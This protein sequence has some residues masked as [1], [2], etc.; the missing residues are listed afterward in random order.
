MPA[1]PGF[2]ERLSTTIV[3][4]LVDVEDRHPVDR[5]ARVVAR[6][7]IGDVV[8]ADD[9][10]DVGARE[11]RVD[12]VHVEERRIRDVGFGEQHVHVARHAAGDGVDRVLDLD[13]LLLELVGEFADAVLRLRDGHAVAGHDDHLVRVREHRRDVVDARGADGPACRRRGT[14]PAPAAT[15]AERAEEHVGDRAVHRF[16][17]HAA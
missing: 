12:V 4:R 7:R 3:V 11:L 10:R 2:I 1:K 9:E 13:A 14:P 15:D 17:H 6:G 16:A 5:A 8:R